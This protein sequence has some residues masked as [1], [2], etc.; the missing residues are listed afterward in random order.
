MK[1]MLS[2][3]KLTDKAVG[4]VVSNNGQGRITID[5]FAQ[6]NEKSVEGLFRVLWRPGGTIYGVSNPRIAVSAMAE[7]KLQGII[8][9]I[10]ISKGL[11]A[12]SCTQILISLRSLQC[13]T[14]RTWR[15]PT[16]TL[17]G[18]LLFIQGTGPRPWK[19]WKSTSEDFT[20]YMD[21]P[22]ATGWGMI[23]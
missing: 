16:R 2:I 4:V 22:S 1:A 5:D 7:V 6:L 13:I 20:E 10:Q 21:N 14:I 8:Y 19:C 11:G 9:Y 12:R 15:Y 17:K 3:M 23:W 18:N